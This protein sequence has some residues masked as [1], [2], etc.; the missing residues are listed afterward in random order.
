MCRRGPAR[1]LLGGTVVG[2][3]ALL[4][5]AALDAAI[6][7]GPKELQCGFPS[8]RFGEP[9]ITLDVELVGSLYG[10]PG[11]APVHLQLTTGTSDMRMA[12]L[13]QPLGPSYA[14]FVVIAGSPMANI[15]FQIG[16]KGDGSASL[17]IRD[18]R[19]GTENASEVTRIGRC[20]DHES[21]F[22]SLEPV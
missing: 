7:L 4:F 18:T 14:P 3:T 6:G 16:L 13:A 20:L 2:A 1:T 17:T 22:L 21:F 11:A 12:A 19:D 5:S 10:G 9:S 15:H 8:A